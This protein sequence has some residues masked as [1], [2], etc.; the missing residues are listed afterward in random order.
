MAVAVLHGATFAVEA[1]R[2]IKNL[3]GSR[4]ASSGGGPQMTAEDL[5]A[6]LLESNRMAD[7]YYDDRDQRLTKR[8]AALLADWLLPQLRTLSAEPPV[9]MLVCPVCAARHE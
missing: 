3:V 8:R 9:K 5:A 6:L 7:A 1:I 4:D 2:I